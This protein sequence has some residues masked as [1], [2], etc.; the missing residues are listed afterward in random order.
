[1]QQE[2]EKYAK[3][4]R[5]FAAC[6]ANVHFMHQNSSELKYR[7]TCRYYVAVDTHTHILING[8]AHLCVRKNNKISG[9]VKRKLSDYS[10]F[11]CV[12]LR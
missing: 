7:V 9:F 11:L 6:D 10:K 1:M 8:F 2:R 4:T 5:R 12:H 3:Y